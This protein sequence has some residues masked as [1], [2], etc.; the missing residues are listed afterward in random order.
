[1]VQLGLQTSIHNDYNIFQFATL[2]QAIF[3]EHA[4]E[5]DVNIGNITVKIS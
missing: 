5:L 2:T 4:R 3:S 1:M